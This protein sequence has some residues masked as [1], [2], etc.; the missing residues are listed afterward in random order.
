MAVCCVCT[1]TVCCVCVYISLTHRSSCAATNAA[2]TVRPAH[3]VVY[4]TLSHRLVLSWRTFEL[5][6]S[7]LLCSNWGLQ[8]DV[9]R[10]RFATFVAESKPVLEIFEARQLR[11]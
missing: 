7:A 10:K 11:H 2:T 8:A 6:F 4:I 3:R 1:V 5:L 9:I